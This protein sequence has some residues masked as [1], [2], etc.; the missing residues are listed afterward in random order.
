MKKRILI[1]ED[2]PDILKMATMRLTY[3]GYEVL[4]ARDGEEA[5]RQAAEGLPIHL[6]LLDI[7]LPKRSGYDVC[8]LLRRQAVTA[9][10][11]VIVF[12]ASESQLQYLAERCAEAGVT[13]WIKKP[14]RTQEL[15]GKIHRAL[16]DASGTEGA[17]ARNPD[18]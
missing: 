11:P 7:K 5:L 12:T 13:D 4:L 8:R 9:T 15:L 18:G 3:E 17:Q 16:G 10:I 1:A 6:I 2:D 14:F